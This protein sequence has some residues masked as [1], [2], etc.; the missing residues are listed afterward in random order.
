MLEGSRVKNILV[1]LAQA[2]ASFV[3][4]VR[5]RHIENATL[6][7]DLTNGLY[8]IIGIMSAFNSLLVM[9]IG[10]TWDVL[11]NAHL[12]GGTSLNNVIAPRFDLYDAFSTLTVGTMVTSMMG[13]QH[14]LEQEHWKTKNTRLVATTFASVTASSTIHYH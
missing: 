4:I 13:G 9:S 2:V 14:L 11:D 12:S 10:G 1:V 3:L 7:L 5:R 8:A 6:L